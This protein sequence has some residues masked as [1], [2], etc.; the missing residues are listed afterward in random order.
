MGRTDHGL[1]GLFALNKL[2]VLRTWVKQIKG[3][4]RLNMNSGKIFQK[5]KFREKVVFLKKA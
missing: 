4:K 2:M 1:K 3:L 5:S